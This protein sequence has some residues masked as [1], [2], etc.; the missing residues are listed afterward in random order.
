MPM[1]GI[2]AEA[3]AGTGGEGCIWLLDELPQG[4]RP[5]LNAV[6]ASAPLWTCHAHTL[7]SLQPL[8]CHEIQERQALKVFG[9]LVAELHNLMIALLQSFHTKSVPC[10]L[11]VQLLHHSKAGP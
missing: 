4:Q 1:L 3:S 9:L 11:I 8:A 10:V 7:Y 5:S 6:F 2:K